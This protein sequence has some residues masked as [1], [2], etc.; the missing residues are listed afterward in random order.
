MASDSKDK[1][2]PPR[3]P[4]QW[5]L[6]HALELGAVAIS[7]LA[8]ALYLVGRAGLMGWYEAAGVPQLVFSWSAQDVVILGL[9]DERTWLLMLAAAGGSALYFGLLSLLSAALSNL[10]AKVKYLNERGETVWS[11]CKRCFRV[12]VARRARQSRRSNAALATSHWR[13][14]GKKGDLRRQIVKAKKSPYQPPL[15]IVVI[16][17]SAVGLMAATFAY[18]GLLLLLYRTPY[19]NALRAFH[20]QHLAASGQEAPMR[21]LPSWAQVRR[22]LSQVERD[23][24][25]LRGQQ[26]L[27]AYPFVRVTSKGTGEGGSAESDCGWLV[28]ASGGMLVLLTSQGLLVKNFGDAGFAWQ[29]QLAGSCPQKPNPA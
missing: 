13:A 10:S 11:R 20:E 7:L 3:E 27:A 15:G 6:D 29:P 2:V 14:L 17:L 25:I 24:A 28:Q 8:A 4:G 22:P 9:T 1:A 12:R 26:Q 19:L 23:Q 21:Q 5:F 18:A 16:L